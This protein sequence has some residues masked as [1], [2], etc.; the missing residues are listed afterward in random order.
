[1]GKKCDLSDFDRGMIVGARRC[2]LSIYETAN[3]LRPLHPMVSRVSR[4]WCKKQKKTSTESQ[5]YGQKC[6]V[7]DRGLRRMAGLVQADKKVTD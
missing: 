7:N 4:E 6:F 3:G 2:G 5:F 1:M